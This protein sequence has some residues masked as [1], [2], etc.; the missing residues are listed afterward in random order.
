M[1][2]HW[3]SH[4]A[5][6]PHRCAQCSRAFQRLDVLKRHARTCE[7]RA[8]GL[9]APSG[10]RRACDLC[11]RQKK[12]CSASQPCQNCERLSVPC[13]YSFNVNQE[14]KRPSTS[15]E[16]VAAGSDSSEAQ[17]L[18]TTEDINPIVETV[19]TVEELAANEAEF[20]AVILAD[21]L[22][23]SIWDAP[24][25]SGSWLDYLNFMPA[26][27]LLDVS[28]NRQQL[29]TTRKDNP[30]YSFRFLD[31]F[32][33]RT[34][35]LE[36]FECGTPALRE[37]TVTSFLQQQVGSNV[38][39]RHLAGSHGGPSAD[40]ADDL[41]AAL[42][43]SSTI[44]TSITGSVPF[45]QNPWLHDPLM[46]KIH[47]IIVIAKEVVTMKPRNSAVTV[48]WSPLLEQKCIEFFSQENVRKFLTLYW[49]IWHPNVNLI[50]RPTFDP[51][52]ANPTLLAA[53][54]VMGEFVFLQ[55]R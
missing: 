54:A 16:S 48:E 3:A 36:S 52:T 13:C 12:A 45:V 46:I 26:K 10:R 18:P 8:L 41:A 23:A 47:Q 2:R 53:M 14:N 17:T 33:R 24:D 7:A 9:I 43:D 34:G 5:S 28:T 15:Q 51:A 35:L 25:T 30:R 37:R 44:P 4:N 21:P 40:V 22:E 42:A 20:N 49:T 39:L 6:R 31:N 29:V 1:Q 27:S 32:T 19:E 11:V 55:E 50:H 38:I